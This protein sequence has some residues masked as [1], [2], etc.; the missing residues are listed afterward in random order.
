MGFGAVVLEV[1]GGALADI[2]WHAPFYIYLIALLIIPAAFMSIGEPKS[3]NSQRHGDEHVVPG[4]QKKLTPLKTI[5]L[6]Y[7]ATFTLMV[8][9]FF[10]RRSF[11]SF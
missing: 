6:I 10:V 9:F 7:I 4:R 1:A 5:F 3:N 11:P 8:L 2:S